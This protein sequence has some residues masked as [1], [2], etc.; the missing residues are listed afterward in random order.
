MMKWL[1]KF[2]DRWSYNKAIRFG[3]KMGLQTHKVEEEDGSIGYCWVLPGTFDKDHVFPASTFEG[4][5][6]TID[7]MTDEEI[8]NYVNEHNKLK[9]SKALE[10]SVGRG[11][12]ALQQKM[13]CT[14][15][16]CIG[17]GCK[18]DYK[19]VDKHGKEYTKLK[20]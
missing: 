9:E 6:E 7:E 12:N 4:N 13:S 19:L 3:K 20:A 14:S 15:S 5:P 1:K 17:K 10:G 8:E 18:N 2:R 11:Y 16:A